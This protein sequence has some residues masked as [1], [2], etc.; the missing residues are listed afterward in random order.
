MKYILEIACGILFLFF[1]YCVHEYLKNELDIAVNNAVDSA[2]QR[3]LELDGY[4]DLPE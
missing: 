1:L 3:Y 2:F 4:T